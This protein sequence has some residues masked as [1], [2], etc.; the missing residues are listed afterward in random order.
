MLKTFCFYGQTVFCCFLVM[1]FFLQQQQNFHISFL[2]HINSQICT[3][4]GTLLLIL[5]SFITFIISEILNVFQLF[6]LIQVNGRNVQKS[7]IITFFQAFSILYISFTL[8]ARNSIRTFQH[9][10]YTEGVIPLSNPI[11]TV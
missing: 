1:F 11:R 5:F 8:S 9:L 4:I 6:L 10:V 3:S 7:H 2:Q